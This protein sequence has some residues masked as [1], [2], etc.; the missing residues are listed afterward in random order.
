ML[1]KIDQINLKTDLSDYWEA[2]RLQC[3]K[4]LML[5]PNH[6]PED[7]ESF[8]IWL[9]NKIE[10]DYIPQPEKLAQALY[11]SDISAKM[12]KDLFYSW[13]F[14]NESEAWSELLLRKSLQKVWLRKHFSSG[15]SSA[16]SGFET[17]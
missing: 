8:V 16:N 13:N 5:D 9:S 2:C 17:E 11:R 1:K 14:E 10:K 15:K 12:A 4:D 7:R 3:L 6:A